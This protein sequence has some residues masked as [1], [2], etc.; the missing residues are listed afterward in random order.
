DQLSF[1]QENLLIG[2]GNIGLVPASDTGGLWKSPNFGDSWFET[3]GG[4]DPKNGLVLT[5]SPQN[6]N[7]PT[8]IDSTKLPSAP[9]YPNGGAMQIG[10]VTISQ[11]T[12]RPES[13]P[14]IYLLIGRPR[15]AGTGN[16]FTPTFF[17]RGQ[18][19]EVQPPALNTS[20]GLYKT[21]NG[22]LS[23]T[24]VMLRE[25]VH[26]MNKPLNWL[27]LFTLGYE[28]NSIG[29]LAVDPANP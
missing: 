8:G 26:V 14:I 7:G 12:D 19:S 11:A 13:E 6:N 5:W 18:T 23:W 17:D 20:W 16:A 2:L 28:S 24:H 10:R 9:N 27:N 3:V 21:K 29:A 15:V 4:H 1:N 22:G 25:N